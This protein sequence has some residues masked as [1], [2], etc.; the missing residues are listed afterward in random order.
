MDED[1]RDK[2]IQDFLFKARLYESTYLE[3]ELA[4]L[5]ASVYEEGEVAGYS[6]GHAEGYCAGIDEGAADGGIE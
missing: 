6:D 2:R 3:H 5:L 1:V 4:A